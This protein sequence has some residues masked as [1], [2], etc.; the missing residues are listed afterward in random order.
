[1]SEPSPDLTSGPVP[2]R[3]ERREQPG[4]S[5]ADPHGHA[6]GPAAPATRRVRLTLAALLVPALLATLAGL[7]ALWPASAD[8]PDR[9]P[10]A[11]EG[12]TVLRAT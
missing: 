10:V 1:M 8:V 6:H 5:R 9:I 12:S 3:R 4:R 11:A 2:G 7:V